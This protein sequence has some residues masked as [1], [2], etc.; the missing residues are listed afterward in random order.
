MRKPIIA[1]NWKMN[2]TLKEARELVGGLKQQLKDIQDVEIV[3][4]PSFTVLGEVA[5]IIQ[6]SNI[7]LGAQNVHWEDSGAY[8]GEVSSLQLKELGCLYAIVGHSERRIYFGE[9][10]E[11]VNKRAKAA[12]ANKLT[13]IICVGERLEQRE[14]GKTF[15]V[16]KD[17]V[18]NGLKGITPEQ[19]KTVIIA[20][21][22]V[23]AIGTGKTAT[24]E[25]AQ[26]AH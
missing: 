26:E 11:G 14:A 4:C 2:K 5:K 1:G 23:W 7:Q 18:E 13:P 22:P 3:V 21:E 12:L 10:N 24:P 20:Y 16:I 9:T 15:E 17:H 25:Q 8:T 6:G 19:V